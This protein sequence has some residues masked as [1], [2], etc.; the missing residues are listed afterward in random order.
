MKI[1]TE[2]WSTSAWCIH[3][4]GTVIPVRV[5]PF[6]ALDDDATEDAAWLFIVNDNYD[7][8]VLIRYIA[9]QMSYDYNIECSW[10]EDEIRDI[11][12]ESLT[13]IECLKGMTGV[14]SLVAAVT[15]YIVGLKPNFKSEGDL[16]VDAT[17]A[18]VDT[19][20]AS[21]KQHLNES[22][23]RVRFGSEY[24]IRVDHTGAMYF[25]TS[26][27]DGFNW[28]STILQFLSDFTSNAR[29]SDV[30]IERDVSATGDHKVYINHM[31]FNDFLMERPMVIES[32][33]K[34][35]TIKENIYEN[36]KS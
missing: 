34:C 9:N 36:Y 8:D 15:S 12:D 24:Q 28:Y 5:H 22:Y 4:N 32:V 3:R 2:A 11:V 33:K 27:T 31:P 21:I 23:L 6:G 29:V 20:G 7:K 30:T 13:D 18:E 35:G 14:S 25:R 17:E 16:L 10:S 1:L 26:S 19:Y